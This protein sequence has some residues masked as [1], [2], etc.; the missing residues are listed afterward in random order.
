VAG[1]SVVRSG[2]V[3]LVAVVLG[4]PGLARADRYT[5]EP[6]AMGG[7]GGSSLDKLERSFSEQIAD[8]LTWLGQEM[9][10]HLGALSMDHMQVR[11]DGRGRRA[12][13]GL[14]KGD[15]QLLS[16]RIAGDVKF[17]RGLARVATKIN[18]TL[19]GTRLQLQLPDFEVVPRNLAGEN[20][21]EI[22]IPLIEGTFEPE[23]WLGIE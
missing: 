23:R 20:Y 3:A 7:G 18:L 14:G 6:L 17:E 21:L 13:I 11:F 22:R 5:G 16:M 2:L 4:T 15:G 10:S 12:R 9:N 1:S 8:R 19:N